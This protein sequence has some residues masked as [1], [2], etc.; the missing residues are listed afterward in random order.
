MQGW[1]EYQILPSTKY[2]VFEAIFAE[3]W[4]RVFDK[5]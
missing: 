2:R 5:V 3:Y 1:T 4:Y